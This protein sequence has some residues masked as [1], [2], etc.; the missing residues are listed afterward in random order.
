MK[1]LQYKIEV[2]EPK[3][4]GKTRAY[5]KVTLGPLWISCRLDE[6]KGKFYL[7]PP[8]TFVESL[9]GTS[10]AGGGVH[11]GWINTVGFSSEFADEVKAKAMSELG[12]KEE[13][14]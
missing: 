9:Q 3:T 4:V 1:N 12:L 5:V 8:S 14:A 10:R 11:S 13:V 6:A 2:K 7:N